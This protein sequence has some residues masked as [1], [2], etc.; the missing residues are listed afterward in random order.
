MAGRFATRVEG[1]RTS[2]HFE[3]RGPCVPYSGL[4]WLGEKKGYLSDWV[5]QQW[6]R[7]T[8]RRINLTNLP[9]LNGPIGKTHSIGKEFF[10]E[11]AKE[12]GLEVD[13]DSPSRGLVPDFRV[14][15]A[16]DDP[17]PIADGVKKFY[18]RTSDY[19][20]DVWSEWCDGFRPFG[21]ALAFL[22]SR[23]LQQLNVPLSSLDTS[24]GVTSDIVQLRDPQSVRP[25]QTA[26]VRE[27]LESGNVLYV[28]AYSVCSIPGHRTPC[29]KVAFPLPNGYALVILKPKTFPD[30]S[31]SVTSS[32]KKFGDPG[33]YFVVQGERGVSWARYVKTLRETIYVYDAEFGSV[34]A[35]H[36]LW[37]WGRR[38]LKMHYRLTVK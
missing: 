25:V 34:R 16:P 35:D 12:R 6:V 30:G 38:F 3:D 22:F 1:R 10:V 36:T 27:L 4:V 17:H 15:V 24:K 2:S 20:L 32:G 18:E 7:V 19:N 14:L 26:W 37:I 33:F 21:K 28:A 8:G 29:V 13:R 5:T 11:Y 31:F 9:W 23:R